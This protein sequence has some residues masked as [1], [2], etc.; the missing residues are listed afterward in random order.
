[1]WLVM[2]DQLLICPAF[3]TGFKV[4]QILTHQ[5]IARRRVYH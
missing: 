2:S 3:H 1:M 4:G 5:E